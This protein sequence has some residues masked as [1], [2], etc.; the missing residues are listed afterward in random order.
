MS[1]PKVSRKGTEPQDLQL[2]LAKPDRDRLGRLFVGRRLPPGPA[3]AVMVTLSLLLWGGLV[4]LV[5]NLF[6]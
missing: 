3:L 5:Y 6:C 2:N 4:Y 1:S